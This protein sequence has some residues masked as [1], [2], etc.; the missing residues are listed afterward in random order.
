MNDVKEIASIYKIRWKI[1]TCFRQ[2]KTK[3]FNLEDLNFKNDNKIILMV[4]IVVMAY[5]LSI[6]QGLETK[7]QKFKKYRNGQKLLAISIFRLGLS[8]LKTK[9]WTFYR[10]MNLLDDIFNSKCPPNPLLVQ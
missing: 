1:E 10:F 9:V 5:V 7:K 4:A 3:G 8:K 6:H 2:L